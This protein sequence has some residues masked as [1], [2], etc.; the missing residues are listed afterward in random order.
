MISRQGCVCILP[1]LNYLWTDHTKLGLSQVISDSNFFNTYCYLI[2]FGCSHYFGLFYS[3]FHL[4]K[5]ILIFNIP[6]LFKLHVPSLKLFRYESLL[7][8][9]I[10]V[11]FHISLKDLNICFQNC[12]DFWILLSRDQN[13]RLTIFSASPQAELCNPTT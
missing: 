1:T 11:K 7:T 8:T 2:P 5:S 12:F 4:W 6:V 3:W 10:S 9:L 13:E